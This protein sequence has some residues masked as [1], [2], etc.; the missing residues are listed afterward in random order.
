MLTDMAHFVTHTLLVVHKD[1]VDTV[2]HLSPSWCPAASQDTGLV[3]TLRLR[4]SNIV[5]GLRVRVGIGVYLLSSMFVVI[6]AIRVIGLSGGNA[7]AVV[8]RVVVSY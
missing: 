5:L 1:V 8:L 6:I 2:F 4:G 3:A 7:F